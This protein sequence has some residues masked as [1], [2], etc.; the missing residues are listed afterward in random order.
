MTIT[1]KENGFE[2]TFT[3]NGEWLYKA[4]APTPLAKKK[5]AVEKPAFKVSESIEKRYH[6]R[7]DKALI[8]AVKDVTRYLT[9]SSGA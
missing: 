2:Y 7:Y 6:Q 3:E 8:D 1:D 5:I 9:K 4:I